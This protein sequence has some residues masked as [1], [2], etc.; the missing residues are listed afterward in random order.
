MAALNPID[1][2]RRVPFFGMLRDDELRALACHCTVRRVAKD[3]LLFAE[4]ESCDG[5]LVVQSGAIKLFKMAESGREQ[6]LLPSAPVRRWPNFP[7]SM[8]GLFRPRPP[9]SKTRRFSFCPSANFS[10]SA[11]ATRR[12]LSPSFARWLGDFVT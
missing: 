8:A 10:T 7:C 9:R 3:E 4:G 2:L 5:L 6:I 1:T 12:W 11:G